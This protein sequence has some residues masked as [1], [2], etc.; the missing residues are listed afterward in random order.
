MGSSPT[1]TTILNMTLQRFTEIWNE[2]LPHVTKFEG[3]PQL[4]DA[5][6]ASSNGDHSHFDEIDRKLFLR[7]TPEETYA[8]FKKRFNSLI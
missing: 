6:I 8:F 5:L 7:N 4:I 1:D 3:S 2:I